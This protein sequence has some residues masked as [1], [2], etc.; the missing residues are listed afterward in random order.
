ME[1]K[2]PATHQE[3]SKNLATTARIPPMPT[4]LERTKL[5]LARIQDLSAVRPQVEQIF[6]AGKREQLERGVDCHGSPF[7]P[8]A[9]S[10]LKS[11]GGTG[12][13]LAPRRAASRIESGYVATATV[14]PTRIKVSAGW[15][16]LD[17][18]RHHVTGGRRLPRRDPSG[19]REQDKQKAAVAVREFLMDK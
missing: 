10:T 2:T 1:G 12:P 5:I 6:V 13:P 17:W 18:V 3:S 4:I 9:E 11:R 7:A 16:G 14:S 15:P 19:F 8:L